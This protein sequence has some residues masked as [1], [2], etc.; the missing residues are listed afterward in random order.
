MASSTPCKI[1]TPSSM[2]SQ[3]ETQNWF[4]FC[5]FFVLFGA[6]LLLL[7]VLCFNLYVVGIFSHARHLLVTDTAHHQPVQTHRLLH[8]DRPPLQTHRPFNIAHRGSNGELPEETAAAYLV[9]K[10]KFWHFFTLHYLPFSLSVSIDDK[11]C[12]NFNAFYSFFLLTISRLCVLTRD[13]CTLLCDC[14]IL[15]MLGH[16]ITIQGGVFVISMLC[17]SLCPKI[18]LETWLVRM[19]CS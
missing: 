9:M 19:S 13:F 17:H 7:W 5:F 8:S 4:S 15:F 6:V 2:S 18:L 12:N 10:W 1:S 14:D 11:R 3:K 16:T